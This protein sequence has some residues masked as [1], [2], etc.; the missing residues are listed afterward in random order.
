[1]KVVF[2]ETKDWERAYLRERLEEMTVVFEEPGTS[3]TESA[4]NH[5]DADCLSPFIQSVLDASVLSKFSTVKLV[6]TPFGRL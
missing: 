1:M 3:P 4:R 5:K 2:F 6:A